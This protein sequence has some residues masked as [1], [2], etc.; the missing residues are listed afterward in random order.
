MTTSKTRLPRFCHFPSSD[1]VIFHIGI[2]SLTG[3]ALDS[4][5][6]PNKRILQEVMQKLHKRFQ[7]KSMALRRKRVRCRRPKRKID[8]LCGLADSLPRRM[9]EA[10]AVLLRHERRTGPGRTHVTARRRRR[11]QCY[12]TRSCLAVTGTVPS[13][14][15]FGATQI[16]RAHHLHSTNN[17]DMCDCVYAAY[18][19]VHL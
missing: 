3:G 15:T 18:H 17:D 11:R 1:T 19:D 10:V 2:N 8:S 4:M 12:Q 5:N 16:F 7:R 14:L 13:L 9:A 6:T